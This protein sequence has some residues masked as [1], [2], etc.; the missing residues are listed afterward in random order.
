VL[1]RQLE[2]KGHAVRQ[3]W[4][5]FHPGA[6][7]VYIGDGTSDEAAFAALARGVTVCVGPKRKTRARFR[8]EDPA[9]VSTFLEKLEAEVR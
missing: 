2:G 7:P 1:P 8:L 6:L 4:R 3:Q 9:E 5:A